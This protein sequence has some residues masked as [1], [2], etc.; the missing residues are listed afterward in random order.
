MEWI[1]PT[2]DLCNCRRVYRELRIHRDMKNIDF[3]VNNIKVTDFPVVTEAPYTHSDLSEFFSRASELRLCRGL[4]STLTSQVLVLPG[5]S[6]F[7]DTWSNIDS[8]EPSLFIKSTNC[9][10]VVPASGLSDSCSECS[11]LKFDSTNGVTT[12]EGQ[13]Q[14]IGGQGQEMQGEESQ[15]QSQEIQGHEIPSGISE[16]SLMKEGP[17]VESSASPKAKSGSGDSVL[18]VTVMNAQAEGSI[19]I[20]QGEMGSPLRRSARKARRLAALANSPTMIKI[21]GDGNSEQLKSSENLMA[22]SGGKRNKRSVKEVAFCGSPQAK[23]GIEKSPNKATP[24]QKSPVVGHVTKADGIGE[25]NTVEEDED[26]LFASKMAAMGEDQSDDADYVP[27]EGE[28]SDVEDPMVDDVAPATPKFVMPV[29]TGRRI[30]KE[31]VDLSDMSL[32]SAAKSS[33]EEIGMSNEPATINEKVTPVRSRRKRR[34]KEEMKQANYACDQCTKTF[35]VLDNLNRHKL[36]HTGEKAYKCKQCDKSFSRSDNMIEHLRRVHLKVRPYK[37]QHCVKAFYDNAELTLHLRSHTGEKPF[38]CRHCSKFFKS[39]RNLSNHIAAHKDKRPKKRGRKAAVDTDHTYKAPPVGENLFQCGVC[40]ESFSSSAHL[41]KHSRNCQNKKSTSAEISASDISLLISNILK[42]ENKDQE[43]FQCA[44]CD[45][46]FGDAVTLK[47]HMLQHVDGMQTFICEECGK[48]CRNET[49]LVSHMKTHTVKVKKVEQEN[50]TLGYQC[51]LCGKTFT[52][53]DNLRRHRVDHSGEK[54]HCCDVC[55]KRFSRTDNLA[56]HVKRKHTGKK[57]I[58]CEI[59]SKMFFDRNDLAVH[60]RSHTGEK[61]Y[62]CDLCGKAFSTS[63]YLTVHR[64]GHLGIKTHE[65]DHCGKLF[66]TMPRLTQHVKRVHLG[67]KP[68]QCE[69]CGKTFVHRS[70]LKQH[71]FVHTGET[72]FKCAQC[73][74]TFTCKFSLKSHERIHTGERPYQCDTCGMFFNQASTLKRHVRVHTGEKPFNCD[75]CGRAFRTQGNLSVHQK[76][77]TGEKPF[78]CELC[79]KAY[80]TITQLKLHIRKK[81]SGLPAPPSQIYACEHCGKTY[82]K[83]SSLILHIQ[84]MH[85]DVDAVGEVG[86]YLCGHCGQS[87]IELGTLTDHMLSHSGESIHEV[88]TDENTYEMAYWLVEAEGSA[89][90]VSTAEISEVL[91]AEVTEGNLEV[92]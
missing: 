86:G 67:E 27:D 91:S 53:I 89:E 74:K 25:K 76:L 6:A 83:R 12:T 38:K 75:V 60:L 65:C 71:M 82:K 81:H 37:C 77:H 9:I 19:S 68:H 56:A 66:G 50:G 31:V 62:Q 42:D 10:G 3:F 46:N 87:F 43:R 54:R 79:E 23:K 63:S 7:L 4:P 26:V 72:P 58:R 44:N 28:T 57:E 48:S 85:G 49:S 80:R 55:G 61:P 47:K 52:Q 90:E 13:G 34:T 30:K 69:E 16:V 1:Q 35:T 21:E 33:T 36:T 8:E 17:A 18:A 22:S 11:C 45:E 78:P 92:E 24:A 2:P 84:K 14:V 29:S 5:Q 64:R 73:D 70:E 51:D 40:E 88:Q 59:C 41:L 39:S 15:G 20:S 32:S